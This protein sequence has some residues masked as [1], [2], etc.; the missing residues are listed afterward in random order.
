[1]IHR[2]FISRHHPYGV[3]LKI[4][5]VVFAMSIAMTVVG[6]VMPSLIVLGYFFFA[7][8]GL[9]LSF[10]PTAAMYLGSFIIGWV[11]FFWLG[12]RV[13]WAGGLVCSALCT[14]APAL[15][16]NS[17]NDAVIT[18]KIQP[19]L[20]LEGPARQVN[21]VIIRQPT[22]RT[23]GEVSLNQNSCDDLCHVML[24]S[25]TVESVTMAGPLPDLGT[26]YR[27]AERQKSRASDAPQE[28]RWEGWR[29]GYRP[30]QLRTATLLRQTEGSSIVGERDPRT[31]HDLSIIIDEKPITL[32]RSLPRAR[33]SATAFGLEIKDRNGVLFRETRVRSERLFTPLVL[34]NGIGAGGGNIWHQGLRW[35]TDKNEERL[36]LTDLRSLS[37]VEAALGQKLTIPETFGNYDEGRP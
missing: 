34:I 16:V 5:L 26:R 13:A 3:P 29:D 17:A 24:L 6:L 10:A 37:A 35:V 12:K 23:Y 20:R 22:F 27:I 11:T 33:L 7:V 30:S 19:D 18:A 4:L 15:F 32:P 8:P 21:D 9:I 1:M 31:Q 28:F 14:V 25:G 2:S 36:R